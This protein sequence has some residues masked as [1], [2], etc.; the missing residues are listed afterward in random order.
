MQSS[1][2]KIIQYIVLLAI[3]GLLIYLS[4]KRTQ[5]SKEELYKA[6]QST[7][8]FWIILSLIVSFFSHFVRAY[9]WNFLL[10][11]E[12]QKIDLLTSNAAVLIGYLAN[13]GLPRM[14]EISR[15][16][17][18]RKYNN[19]PFDKALGTVIAE[20]VVDLVLLFIVFILVVV[21]QYQDLQLL[22]NKYI[23]LPLSQK[24][25]LSKIL[26]I[27]LLLALGLIALY[28]IN[29]RNKNNTNSR[30]VEKILTTFQNLTS[31]LLSIHKIK[32]PLAF[33]SYSLIIWMLYFLS[34]YLCALSM[35]ATENLGLFK[36]MVLFLF[37]TIGVIV[38]PGGIGAYHFLLTE[39]LLFYQV[40]N[41]S[42]VAFPWII[43]GT[44]F[45]LILF[46]GG[47]SFIL[48]PFFHQN[49]LSTN[50]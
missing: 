17:V 10:E 19:I 35:P 45:L 36:I 23:L 16:A 20:R 42:A 26:F 28:F 40:D 18:V 33:W 48:L 25:S 6:F 32:N 44:Q 8:V 27:I 11:K 43:W 22:L 13:Y 3:G 46:L 9:R 24:F 49:K 21:F 7:H 14:G 38:T 50:G 41:A 37:G 30:I 2:K 34:M 31:P 4:I 1:V 29:K 47:L 5:V 15:C 12:A 39:L